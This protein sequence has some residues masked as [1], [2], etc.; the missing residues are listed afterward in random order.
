MFTRRPLIILVLGLLWLALGASTS[1]A[2]APVLFS[3]ERGEWFVNDAFTTDNGQ[4]QGGTC[5]FGSG[6]G[7][8]D[9]AIEDAVLG[10][11]TPQEVATDTFDDATMV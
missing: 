5:N 7:G 2:N 11:D 4:P 10:G 9:G 3:G 1:W 8:S 6:P